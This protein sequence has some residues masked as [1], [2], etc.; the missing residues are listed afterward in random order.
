MNT[1]K[2]LRD[3][4]Q[5]DWSGKAVVV[6]EEEGGNHRL[7][8]ELL[9]K[10]G[11]TVVVVPETREAIDAIRELKSVDLMIL[12]VR[13]PEWDDVDAAL[14]I[15]YL[16]PEIPMVIQTDYVPVNIRFLPLHRYLR[17][18]LIRPW[19]VGELIDMLFEYLKD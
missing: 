10:T 2:T 9:M 4:T 5:N 1:L 19:E 15:G 6:V 7:I 12:N 13:F 16:W 18:I 14:Q 3:L 17:G 11:A 8:E